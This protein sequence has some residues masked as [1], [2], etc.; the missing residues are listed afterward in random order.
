MEDRSSVRM[1]VTAPDGTSF[2]AMSRITDQIANYLYDS[3]PEQSFVFARTPA[4]SANNTAQPRIGLVP[5]NERQRTQDQ[6]ANDLQKK[7]KTI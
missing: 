4:G 5:P 3:V 1:V 7:L 6:I 2:N